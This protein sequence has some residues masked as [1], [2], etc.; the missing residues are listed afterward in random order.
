[1]PWLLTTQAGGAAAR[2]T[3]FPTRAE[4]EQHLKYLLE[5]EPRVLF[6]GSVVA[7]AL[8]LDLLGLLEHSETLFEDVWRHLALVAKSCGVEVSY[9][10]VVDSLSK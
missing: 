5:K 3:E 6:G 8:G 2:Y 4:L 1:M 10:Y 9:Q 7:E